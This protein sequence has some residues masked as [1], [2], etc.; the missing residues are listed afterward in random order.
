M[1]PW[2]DLEGIICQVRKARERQILDHCTLITVLDGSLSFNLCAFTQF[3]FPPDIYK[4]LYISCLSLL[5]ECKLQ[6]GRDL[7][8]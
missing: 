6:E 3:S 5:L 4:Y 8:Y 1:T 2:I 7:S